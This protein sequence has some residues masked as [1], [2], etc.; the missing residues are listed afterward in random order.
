[1]NRL[2]LRSHESPDNFRLLFGEL[3][4][5]HDGG[6]LIGKTECGEVGQN[7]KPFLLSGKRMDCGI[8]G[9]L[10]LARIHSR[11]ATQRTT[12]LNDRGIFSRCE[13]D[14]LQGVASDELTGGTEPADGY[15]SPTQ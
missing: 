2:Q 14:F 13:A 10:D 11:L 1:M 7:I 12:D 15:G 9:G 4:R 5:R 6:V 8:N 3:A